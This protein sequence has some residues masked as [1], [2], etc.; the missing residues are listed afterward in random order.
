[1]GFGFGSTPP[2]K[3][4]PLVSKLLCQWLADNKPKIPAKF[5][6]TAINLNCNYAGRRHRDQNNEG[7]SVIRAFGKFKGGRLHY[8]RG[9]KKKNPRPELDSLK[10]SDAVILDLAKK[11]SIFDGNRA[12]EVE[13][14]TGE[15][16]STV[17]FTARGWGK[18]KPK[19]VK[20]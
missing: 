16:Y 20:F 13:P 9:D 14:F 4:Y 5:V 11:T 7:P 19:D 1:M 6:C 10:K 12:H 15:R 17:F 3:R 2:T 8:F 18:G